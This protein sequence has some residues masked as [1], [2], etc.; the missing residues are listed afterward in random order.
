LRRRRKSRRNRTVKAIAVGFAS[1]VLAGAA[2]L[3]AYEAVDHFQSQPS[4]LFTDLAPTPGDVA[5]G[6]GTDNPSG[7]ARVAPVM[8]T[9]VLEQVKDEGTSDPGSG[10]DGIHWVRGRVEVYRLSMSQP[11][12]SGT[13]EITS[14][15]ATR[16]DGSKQVQGSWILRTGQGAWEGSLWRGIVSADGADQF[17]LGKATGAGGL[18]GLVLLLQWHVVQTPGSAPTGEGSSESIAVSGWIQSVK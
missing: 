7:L 3:G 11:L 5:A 15:L 9:A 14:D 6:W 1:I 13:V 16:L 10:A 12:V 17:Y 2:A 18:E 8:G 4:L